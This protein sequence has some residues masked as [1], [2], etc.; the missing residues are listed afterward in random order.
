MNDPSQASKKNN[1]DSSKLARIQAVF[2]TRNNPND[3]KATSNL[4]DA[5]GVFSYSTNTNTSG[6]SGGGGN[7]SIQDSTQPNVVAALAQHT[8]TATSHLP[9]PAAATNRSPLTQA[10]SVD[11][12]TL[13]KQS[14]SRRVRSR[15]K[16]D[17]QS[18]SDKSLFSRIF[19]KKS[20]K[21][22]RGT[23]ITT[24]TNSIDM[25]VNSQRVNLINKTSLT[26]SQ[27]ETT[28]DEENEYN[29]DDYDYD[30]DN[31]LDESMN[32]INVLSDSDNRTKNS[33]GTKSKPPYKSVLPASDSQ[34]YASMS[35]APTGFSISYHKHTTKGPNDLRIQAALTRLQQ[36]S[37]KTTTSGG[38][39]Q[40]MVRVFSSF[41]R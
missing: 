38:S 24:T 15:S 37:K 10:N 2:S 4:T 9:S 1:N 7:S 8:T 12:P 6:D 35:S 18:I 23:L 36:Q 31:I 19:S 20:S 32:S 34:Y 14:F 28:I 11:T 30:D 33:T 13:S 16:T 29:P 39:A 25:D 17:N 22:P 26:P 27:H 5:V 21:K 3:K 40:L 41:D